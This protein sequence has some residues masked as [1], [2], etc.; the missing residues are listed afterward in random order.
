MVTSTGPEEVAVATKTRGHPTPRTTA[1]L[2]AVV[3]TMLHLHERFHPHDNRPLV[4]GA[5]GNSITFGISTNVS[6]LH[7][8]EVALN[9]LSVLDSTRKVL[10]VH[11]V[12][13]AVR[14][15]SADFA[16][17]CYDEIWR[18]RGIEPVPKL[19]VAVI[20][21]SFTSS[22]SQM[23]FL[24][25]RLRSLPRPP[26]VLALLYCPHTFWHKV[27][28]Q[29]QTWYVD[30]GDMAAQSALPLAVSTNSTSWRR[31][32]SH[33]VNEH[34][35]EALMKERLP[36]AM[37]RLLKRRKIAHRVAARAVWAEAS[38]WL[39][40]HPN[41]AGWLATRAAATAVLHHKDVRCNFSHPIEKSATSCVLNG[42]TAQVELARPDEVD[43]YSWR[44]AM[45]AVAAGECLG[46]RLQGVREMLHA[47]G[48]PYTTNALQLQRTAAQVLSDGGN[49]GSH[50]NE[51]GHEIMAGAVTRLI[52]EQTTAPQS[53]PP[54]PPPPYEMR[55]VGKRGGSRARGGA[56]QQVC[57]MGTSVR[58]LF[59]AT[60]SHG[61]EWVDP[62]GGRTPGLAATETGAVATL[63][64]QSP[65]LRTG[66]MS[67][68]MEKSYWSRAIAHISCVAP[69]ECR[70][71][72]YDVHADKRYTYAQR[73]TPRWVTLP[74]DG[75]VCLVQVRVDEHRKGRVMVQAVT[76]AAPLA[77]NKSVSTNTL[78]WLLHRDASGPRRKGSSRL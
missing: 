55:A 28:Q 52:L 11:T 67:L 20:D 3:A 35:A 36:P 46:D 54:P 71:V 31:E 47:R 57:A 18:L 69:C 58:T 32:R 68:G 37:A 76:L 66:Y 48:V 73:S 24:V 1:A 78:Y 64:L 5:L 13:G 77:G 15:S 65:S 61:F 62:G 6:W 41:G 33:Y 30:R 45:S 29:N 14:A 49:F 9:S 70:H 72:T 16:A 42:D 27:A 4:I 34:D 21:Y 74:P 19:D 39:P 23:A 38:G 44:R 75:S 25:D 40:A 59:D 60:R 7:S 2:L 63:R 22:V 51:L 56:M 8:V 12:N 53:P 50:P 17:L 43:E 10:R 26:L